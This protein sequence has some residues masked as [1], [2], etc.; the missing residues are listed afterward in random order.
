MLADP[1]ERVLLKAHGLSVEWR[2]LTQPGTQQQRCR[3]QVQVCLEGYTVI[4]RGMRVLEVAELHRDRTGET[5][6]R[7]G[8][9]AMRGEG[10]D[11]GKRETEESWLVVKVDEVRSID[12]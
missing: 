12:T 3:I 9:C 2:H 7:D 4:E 10:Q 5:G 8:S 6:E 11:G 1:D